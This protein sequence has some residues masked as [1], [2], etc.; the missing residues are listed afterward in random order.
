MSSV[1]TLADVGAPCLTVPAP[2][3]GARTKRHSETATACTEGRHLVSSDEARRC[4]TCNRLKKRHLWL[5]SEWKKKGKAECK[6]CYKK[7]EAFQRNIDLKYRNQYG[8]TLDEYNQM[9]EEQEYR[10]AVCDKK[11]GR[12]RLAVDH[13]HKAEKRLGTRRSIRGLLCRD[14]NEY[15]GHIGDSAAAAHRM[16]QYLNAPL[17]FVQ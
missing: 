6:S 3:T 5:A 2:T 13:D 9:L 15:L 14:C 17:R 11:P 8:I 16:V 7:S 4:S 10:C 12:R 1:P